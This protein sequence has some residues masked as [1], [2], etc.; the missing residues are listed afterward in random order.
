MIPSNSF[1]SQTLIELN[2]GWFSEGMVNDP[3]G[4]FFIAE[5]KSFQRYV[6]INNNYEFIKTFFRCLQFINLLLE[7]LTWDYDSKY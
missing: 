1:L 5:N 7:S 2:F 4:G 6:S 3:Y